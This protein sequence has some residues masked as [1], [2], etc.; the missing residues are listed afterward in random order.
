METEREKIWKMTE[1]IVKLFC[2]FLRQELIDLSEIPVNEILEISST[3]Y[4]INSDVYPFLRTDTEFTSME[5]AYNE[6]NCFLFKVCHYF[7][8]SS[9]DIHLL[10]TLFSVLS[11][12]FLFF[13]FPSPFMQQFSSHLS[14]SL[15]WSYYIDFWV[16]LPELNKKQKDNITNDTI[17]NI[18]EER[19]TYYL[20]SHKKQYP[21]IISS[22]SS[23]KD[24]D[25]SFAHNNIKN[26]YNSEELHGTNINNINGSSKMLFLMTLIQSSMFYLRLLSS[27][28]NKKT[29]IN[30]IYTNKENLTLISNTEGKE[31]QWE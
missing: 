31:K 14:S 27:Q 15:L 6:I 4:R 23:S 28:L 20:P 30:K 26:L 9:D 18:S 29:P 8:L 7:Q 17:E 22:V 11:M 12:V 2:G 10:P 13:S 16:S 3:C 1:E 24:K 21:M 25:F 19:L 5:E